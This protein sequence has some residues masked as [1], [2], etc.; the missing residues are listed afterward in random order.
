MRVAALVVLSLSLSL[1]ACAFLGIG[2]TPAKR[3][4][5]LVASGAFYVRASPVAVYGRLQSGIASCPS[6]HSLFSPNNVVAEPSPDGTGGRI[7]MV[8]GTGDDAMTLWGARVEPSGDEAKIT[9]Y[10]PEGSTAGAIGALLRMWAYGR[11]QHR[12]A[13]YEFVDC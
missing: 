8:D 6:L 13:S 7:A 4:P 5:A 10:E 3:A 1:T 12:T 2:G 9:V 11:H